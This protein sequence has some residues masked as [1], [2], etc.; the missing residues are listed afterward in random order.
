MLEQRNT[1]RQCKRGQVLFFIFGL[2][3]SLKG[4]LFSLFSVLQHVSNSMFY[5]NYI[6]I[7]ECMH[8]LD[9]IQK[10][11][12]S[13]QNRVLRMIVRHRPDNEHFIIK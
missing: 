7:L 10:Q 13:G 9:L 6:Y 2:D 1:Q 5:T 3:Q 8:E 12:K 11:K 4:P